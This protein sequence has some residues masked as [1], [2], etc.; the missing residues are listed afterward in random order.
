M[1]ILFAGVNVIL[2]TFLAFLSVNL[3]YAGLSGVPGVAVPERIVVT[4][5]DF[6]SEGKQDSRTGRLPKDQLSV[7]S[8]R[9]LFKVALV[10]TSATLPEK[11]IPAVDALEETRLDLKLAG[12]I[13]LE[14]G[15]SFAVIQEGRKKE[16][17]RYQKGDS[18]QG[19]EIKAILREKVVLHYKNQ[20]EVLLMTTAKGSG[21]PMTVASPPAGVSNVSTEKTTLR[22]SDV[23]DALGNI[24]K[25]MGDARLRPHFSKG[26]PDGLLIYGIKRD[27]LFQT[28]GLKNGDILTGVGGRKIE[29]VDDAL[30]FYEKLK[31][32]TD[33]NV[34]LKRRGRAKEIQYHVE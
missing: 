22:R 4:R 17:K 15:E 8:K 1:K 9:N 14:S 13:I 3:L 18:V 20:D 32:D 23:N 21:E 6:S 2:L 24:N 34:Q 5:A 10:K 16:Q 30:E 19:A 26:K 28:M 11:E 31:D 25:L 7:I 29:S 33:V 27:S 12:T